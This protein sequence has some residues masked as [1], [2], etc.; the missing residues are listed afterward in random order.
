MQEA[1][2]RR[3]C[4]VEGVIKCQPDESL[5]TIIDRIVKAEV[6]VCMT[7]FAFKSGGQVL[8]EPFYSD[9]FTGWSWW[10]GL[11]L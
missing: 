2:Q 4:C 9:R 8:K 7:C 11:T 5:E 3:S 6:G 1:I 10:T